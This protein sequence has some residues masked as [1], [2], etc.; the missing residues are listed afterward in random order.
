MKAFHSAY[1]GIILF[2]QVLKPCT[3]FA[4]ADTM[5]H[6]RWYKS[7]A[8][9]TLTAPTVLIGYGL[10][11]IGPHGLYS[12]WQAKHD[13]QTQFPNFHT[14][15]DNAMPFVPAAGFY[16]LHLSGVPSRHD[17]WNA[18]VLYALSSGVTEAVTYSIKYPAHEQRPDKSN[19]LSFPS[20]HTAFAFAAAEFLHQEYKDESPWISIGGY[21]VAA[22]TGSMRM[23]NNK[24]WLCDVFVGAGV[25]MLSTKAVYLAYPW[26]QKRFGKRR[27]HID[28]IQE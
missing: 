12:S 22:A 4:Q 5:Q 2:L 11:S 16:I 15:I 27:H 7:T 17:L 18:T 24:H 23:L 14:H 26:L 25:G 21:T 9:R 6:V 1:I 10:T 8:F 20:A 28:W 13:L 19:Y 3:G